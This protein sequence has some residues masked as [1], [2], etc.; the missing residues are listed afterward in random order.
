MAWILDSQLEWCFPVEHDNMAL[1]QRGV[2]V[3]DRRKVKIV[4]NRDGLLLSGFASS[5]LGRL[6]MLLDALG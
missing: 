6:L 1:C 3:V 2:K 5:V 4:E